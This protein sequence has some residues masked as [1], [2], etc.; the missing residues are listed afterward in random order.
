MI[1]KIT[2]MLAA[3]LCVA[4]VAN[5]QQKP[6]PAPIKGTIFLVDGTKRAG[7]IRWSAKEKAYIIKKQAGATFIDEQTPPDQVE[8]LD[9]EKPA[10]WDALAKAVE[11]GKGTAAIPRLEAIAKQYAH[12]QWDKE[13]GRYLAQAYIAQGNFDKALAAANDIIKT[14]E[15]AAYLGVLAPMYWQALLKKGQN[16]KLEAALK[17]A[18]ASG[19]RYAS[20]AALIM[21]G[22]MLVE[23][24]P[25]D[26]DA[27]LNALEDGYLRVVLMYNDAGV[28]EHLRPEALAK[29]AKCFETA[30]MAPRAA[31]LRGQ[32]RAQYPNS[33]WVSK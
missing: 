25:G 13:A 6:A 32:L 22:D 21:R 17:K 15:T 11:A 5:A 28:A 8:R 12:L 33:P 9:I 23:G 18:V 4:A 14:D 7:A 10:Q 20:G 30:G 19:D 1:R 27:A 2:L 3:C 16:S 29:A 26:R 31:T 24:K